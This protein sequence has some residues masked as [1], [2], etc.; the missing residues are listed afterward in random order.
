MVEAWV[1]WVPR[2]GM[3]WLSGDTLL[4]PS[5]VFQEFIKMTNHDVEHAIRKRMS[6]DVRDAF[7]AIGQCLPGAPLPASA[8][9]TSGQI[10]AA[11][12]PWRLPARRGVRA[13]IGHPMGPSL[14]PYTK[15]G[16]QLTRWVAQLLAVTSS[17]CHEP[18]A[19]FVSPLCCSPEREEQASLLC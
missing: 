4:S 11:F 12:G 17:G 8:K 2:A 6:G 9:A 3:G 18:G 7:L 15:E 10:P 16:L 19:H 1:S 14:H 13:F 5:P